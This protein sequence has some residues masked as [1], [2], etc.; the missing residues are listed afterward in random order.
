MSKLSGNIAYC[1]R[2]IRGTSERIE[3]LSEA[4]EYGEENCTEI[5]SLN[6]DMLL[7]EITALQKLVLIITKSFTGLYAV[8]ETE[9]QVNGDNEG[10]G[11]FMS[12]ELNSVKKGEEVNPEKKEDVKANG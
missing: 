1:A 5:T 4:C 11:V 3:S 9:A 7:S 12:G 2:Q 10:G 8:K 6:M